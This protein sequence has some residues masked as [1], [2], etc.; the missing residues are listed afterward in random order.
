MSNLKAIEAI[1][2]NL[3]ADKAH[4]DAMDFLVAHH[5]PDKIK[6]EVSDLITSVGYYNERQGFIFGFR[7][8]LNLLIGAGLRLIDDKDQGGA[9][10]D[11]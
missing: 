3:E 8:A 10:G 11:V 5:M 2:L 9:S 7:Y 6:V 1:W 4:D